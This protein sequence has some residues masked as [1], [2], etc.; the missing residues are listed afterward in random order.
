[1]HRPTQ[2]VCTVNPVNPLG[3]DACFSPSLTP[4]MSWEMF[5]FLLARKSFPTKVSIDSR[6]D[7]II[8]DT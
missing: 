6:P 8:Q 2:S 3:R 1:M 5:L 7:Q 4:Q